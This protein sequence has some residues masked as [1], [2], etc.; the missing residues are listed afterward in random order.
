MLKLNFQ[1]E[2]LYAL[3]TIAAV[4]TFGFT[5]N[6]CFG[7]LDWANASKNAEP[8][9]YVDFPLDINASDAETLAA[10][11]GVGAG[12]AARIVGYR[13]KNS[14]FRTRCE[15]RKVSGIGPR[16]YEKIKDKIYVA[17][18]QTPDAL[19]PEAALA[20]KDDG[21]ARM[22]INR[23]T[24]ENFRAVKG[25]GEALGRKI[26]EFRDRKGGRIENFSEL[27]AVGGIGSKRMKTIVQNFIIE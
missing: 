17:Y 24:I 13:E 9:A 4:F 6:L 25:V 19:D 2:E 12:L 5:V 21:M 1:K 15:I 11:P 27:T 14:E 23:A 18:D 22:D 8:K 3:L 10:L 26:V 7:Y 16:L 20:P